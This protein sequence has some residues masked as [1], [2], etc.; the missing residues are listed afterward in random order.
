MEQSFGPTLCDLSFHF[1]ICSTAGLY[2]EI[3][4]QDA[5]KSPVSLPSVIQAPLQEAP[6]AGYNVTFV[7]PER[8]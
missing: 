2:T 4:P 3:Q 1:T 8:G 7:Y 6:S 5:Y